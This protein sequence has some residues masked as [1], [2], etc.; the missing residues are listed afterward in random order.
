M[1]VGGYLL[2]SRTGTSIPAI[3]LGITMKTD[4]EST[5]GAY[6]LVEY[7]VPPGVDGPPMHTHTREDESFVC[8]AGR[9][10]VSL[11][12]DVF[13]LVHGDYLLLP[14]H[15]PH[16]FRNPYDDEARVMSV[17]SPAGLERYYR[18]L[19]EMPPGKR[20]MAKMAS[21][22]EDFGIE[23]KLPSSTS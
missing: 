1:T 21:I 12:G 5:H 13:E 10:E 2:T 17:V 22:M 7:T 19:A 3:G 14:R 16:A 4:G 15:V 20:D 9:L 23:M 8:L 6:S 11:G 18:A